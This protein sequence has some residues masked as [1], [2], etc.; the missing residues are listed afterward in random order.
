MMHFLFWQYLGLNSGIVI[1]VK[2]TL[3]YLLEIAYSNK[4]DP[5]QTVTN[6]LLP[7]SII[8]DKKPVG[9]AHCPVRWNWVAG[10]R[11]EQRIHKLRPDKQHADSNLVSRVSPPTI[12]SGA[13]TAMFKIILEKGSYCHLSTSPLKVSPWNMLGKAELLKVKEQRSG[14][15]ISIF[16]CQRLLEN[17]QMKLKQTA[18]H[19]RPCCTVPATNE[20]HLWPGS[21]EQGGSR[22][23]DSEELCPDSGQDHG[24]RS[25]VMFNQIPQWSSI[26]GLCA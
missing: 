20:K 25:A 9:W 21:T 11:R 14:E 3:C 7:W 24:Q 12:C 22:G 18:Q 5:L 6:L 10:G 16:S 1:Y 8:T 17:P 26:M 13:L 19:T 2:Y 23:G 4:V 15:N